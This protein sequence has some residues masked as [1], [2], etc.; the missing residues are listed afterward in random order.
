MKTVG[1]LSTEALRTGGQI[2]KNTFRVL[3][4]NDLQPR[5]LY[6]QDYCANRKQKKR[7]FQT[8]MQS[9][10]LPVHAASQEETKE[11]VEQ[12]PKGAS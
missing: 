2:L 8:S 9:K 5:I 1:N 12:K 6:H 4:E 7:Y 3:R 11:Y 10:N